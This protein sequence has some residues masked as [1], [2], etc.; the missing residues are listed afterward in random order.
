MVALDTKTGEK[1]W[2]IT[3][4]NYCWSSP[5]GIYTAENKGYIIQCDSAGKVFLIDGKTGEKITYIELGSNIE[6]SPA[7]FEN[8]LVVGTRGGLVCGVEIG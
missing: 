4:N 1:V 3:M 8:H 7:I 5:A 2:E 6:A